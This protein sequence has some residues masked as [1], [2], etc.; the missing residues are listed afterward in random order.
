MS[1]A[2]SHT[3]ETTAPRSWCPALRVSSPTVSNDVKRLT[4]VPVP[5][6]SE[7]VS[8]KA[9]RH[10]LSSPHGVALPA[11]PAHPRSRAPGGGAEAPGP[12]DQVH[13]RSQCSANPPHVWEY[14]PRPLDASAEQ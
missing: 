9:R 7:E 12:S 11:Q 6:D 4:E 3:H 1:G 5:L 14:A 13:G 8:C 2:A 10:N